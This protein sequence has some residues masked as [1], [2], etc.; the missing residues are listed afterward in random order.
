MRGIAGALPQLCGT[1]A[2]RVTIEGRRAV[3][4]PGLRAQFDI[5]QYIVES[6]T[7]ELARLEAIEPFGGK[8]DLHLIATLE[9]AQADLDRLFGTR[10]RLFSCL[11]D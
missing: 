1:P 11:V 4:R 7:I 6:Q 10:G 2:T 3:H 9:S 5:V 8:E